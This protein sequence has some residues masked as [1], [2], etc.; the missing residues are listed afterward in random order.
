MPTYVYRCDQCGAV[1]ERRQSF[2]DPP[3]SEC[4]ACGGGLRRVVQP[5]SVIFRGSGFYSTD[6]RHDPALTHVDGKPSLAKGAEDHPHDPAEP[7]D[8]SKTPASSGTPT[9]PAPP[10]SAAKPD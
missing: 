9:V 5:V 8:S 1:L 10:G 3:L 7:G 6:Y 4:D 2:Q